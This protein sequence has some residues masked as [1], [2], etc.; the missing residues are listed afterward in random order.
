MQE[1]VKQRC[2]SDRLSASHNL[3]LHQNQA[4]VMISS[5]G[6]S[7]NTLVFENIRFIPKF[8]RGH[9]ERGRFIKLGLHHYSICG[10]E[11]KVNT[12]NNRR[13]LFK[14]KFHYADF[15]VTFAT[16]PRQTRDVPV[17]L[18]STSPTSPCLVAGGHR[19][20]PRFS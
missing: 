1:L 10:V 13:E 16:S 9:P 20:L 17:D 5:P 18:F 2:L 6:E 11:R 14:P 19:R 4:S 3:V 7:S 12:A 15:P 8:E